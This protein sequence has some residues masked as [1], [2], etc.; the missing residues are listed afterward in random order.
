MD[1]S[2]IDYLV[3]KLNSKINK[4]LLNKKNTLRASNL[5]F[6]EMEASACYLRKLDMASLEDNNYHIELENDF[7]NKLYNESLKINILKAV[8]VE[9]KYLGFRF[10][11]LKPTE[12]LF[13]SDDHNIKIT[14]EQLK[15]GIKLLGIKEF[16]EQLSKDIVFN[17]QFL[18][19]DDECVGTIL[20]KFKTALP[21]RCFM[22]NNILD[23]ISQKDK[24]SVLCEVWIKW[25][26]II[27][28]RNKNYIFKIHNDFPENEENN[29]YDLVIFN[30]MGSKQSREVV[31]GGVKTYM[32]PSNYQPTA[33][34]F[35]CLSSK[36]QEKLPHPLGLRVDFDK[37]VPNLI[38][39]ESKYQD[40]YTQFHEAICLK[41]LI[42]D[43]RI[44]NLLDESYID[45]T[46]RSLYKYSNIMVPEKS[47]I[48]LSGNIISRKDFYKYLAVNKNLLAHHDFVLLHYSIL[49]R[50]FNNN[51]NMIDL[52]LRSMARRC[53]VVV[54]SGRGTPTGLPIEVRFIH[55]SSFLH[56]F[57]EV[58]SKHYISYV[59]HSTRKSNK[60]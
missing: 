11:V 37:Y 19:Y 46:Y 47:E 51:K 55:L 40:L 2:A 33:L 4:S 30:H 52:C 53:N 1:I 12:V 17:H 54:T 50:V 20:L 60:I 49:E 15:G 38:A 6:I 16:E 32:T 28:K 3:W 10:Y 41:T 25:G 57:S 42:I 39:F 43:E 29:Q 36:A 26:A 56:A 7:V 18:I 27:K 31:K 59:L 58:R 14:E 48:N 9:G 34:F 35:E 21:L 44:Q 8:K 24:E 23:L 5:G 22:Y 13:V 45:V